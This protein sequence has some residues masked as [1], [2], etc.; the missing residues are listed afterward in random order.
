[1]LSL[2]EQ[3]KNK[4]FKKVYLLYGK[5]EFLKK[6]YRRFL[7]KG[8]LPEDE[9]GM[10]LSVYSGDK[11]DLE[12]VLSQADTMPFFAECRVI[13]VE[14]SGFF[15]KSNDRL[16]K[17]LENEPDTTRF[18]FLEKDVKTN[19]KQVKNIQSYGHVQELTAWKGEKLRSWILK[20]LKKQGKE[21]TRGAWEEFYQ[22]TGTNT[23]GIEIMEYMSIEADKLC[24]Y[25]LDKD[26][27]EKEDVEAI[28]S[29]QLNAKVFAMIDALAEKRTDDMLRLYR[30]LMESKEAPES[31]LRLIQNNFLQLLSLDS[32]IKRGAGKSEMLAV[33]KQDWRIDKSRRLL[34]Y[35]DS[36]RLQT[37]LARSCYYDE[38][39]KSGRL[40]R[41]MALELLMMEFSR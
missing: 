37:C 14:D 27:I 39:L 4:D 24:M 35:M 16:A 32:M 38:M 30:D 15:N 9:S 8:M 36:N 18:I 5:E 1:M 13:V 41:Y 2:D 26:V 29:G 6:N 28:C 22:R 31:I 40:D 20:R 21:M 25:C 17:Y 11:I 7:V 19:L 23:E 34:R 12:E 3:I 10:N 33:F